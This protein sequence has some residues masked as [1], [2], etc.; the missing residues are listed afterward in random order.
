M[1]DEP[2]RP[3][4]IPKDQRQQHD[5][6]LVVVAETPRRDAVTWV[7]NWIEK[8]YEAYHGEVKQSKKA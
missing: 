6:A 4:Y 7:Y 2:Q 3:F 8:R 1:S 5:R